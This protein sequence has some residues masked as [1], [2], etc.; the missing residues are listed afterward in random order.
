MWATICLRHTLFGSSVG[1]AFSSEMLK[2]LNI[3][4]SLYNYDRGR[5][6]IQSFLHS[7]NTISVA[8]ISLFSACIIYC[9]IHEGQRRKAKRQNQFF[10]EAVGVSI[11]LTKHVN[12]HTLIYE[13]NQATRYSVLI[14]LK[15]ITIL[16][17]GR[18][19]LY[20]CEAMSI[21]QILDNRIRDGDEVARL[22]RRP[23]F[24]PLPG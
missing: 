1:F 11:T 14:K 22:M 5:R 12:P 23:H 9:R 6:R 13:V 24:T 8:K 15:I 17:I 10:H 4:T 2:K 21:P 3:Q 20:S 18:G 16:I 19:G 7:F